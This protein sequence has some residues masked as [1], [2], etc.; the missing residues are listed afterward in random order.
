MNSLLK[1]LSPLVAL[2]C[3]A[4]VLAAD[5]IVRSPD[6]R[7]VVVFQLDKAGVPSYRVA[8]GGIVVLDKSQLGIRR[9]DID[10]SSGLR[11]AGAAV[12][13]KVAD[14]YELPASKRRLNK[15]RAQR[16]RIPLKGA[17]SRRLD[18]VFQVSNDGVAFRYEF[19]DGA[20]QRHRIVDETSSFHFPKDTLAWLQPMA[21]AKSGWSQTNPSY[22]EHYQQGI[23]AGTPSTLGAGWVFPALFRN[24]STWVA[25]T[26]VGLRRGSCGARLRHEAPE[27]EY[28]IG[29]AD[30]RETHQGMDVNPVVTLPWKG[31]WRVIAIGS[32][33]SLVESS[34]GT[35]LADPAKVAVKSDGIKGSVPRPVAPPAPGKA[36]WSWALL[37][38]PGTTFDVQRQFIDYAAGM[39]WGYCLVDALWDTQIGGEKSAE[40]AKY[41]AS[42]G[43]KLLL[44]YN[45]NGDWNEAPQTPKDKLHTKESRK[46]EFERLSAMGISGLKVDFFGGDGRPVIDSY[47][48]ILE[49]SAP[50]GF[51]LNFHGATLPRGW[52]R[53]YPHLLTMEAIRGFE[54]ITFEQADADVAANHCA[55]LPFTRNLFDPMDFT[56]VCLDRIGTVQ[57]RTTPG[58]ELAT[59]VLF[60]S[61]I[62]HYVET[63]EGMAKQPDHVR[64]FLK[65]VP[66]VW[67]DSRFIDGFPGK[68][69]VIARRAGEQWFIAGINGEAQEKTLTLDLSQLIARGE[70]KLIEDG[71][72]GTLS[73]SVLA[74][75]KSGTLNVT[76][77]PNGGF[78]AVVD[79]P[80]P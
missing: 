17:D 8:S 25:L 66:S 29:Y 32:L 71:P 2:L 59:S 27:G 68:H 21:V 52:Q 77:Q 42:K 30:T 49:E 45:S 56:P 10:F 72:A 23:P 3:L 40:L 6:G 78:S 33:A 75:G 69:V 35:D 48:D 5:E 63:P 44:W 13:D 76:L 16:L 60:L 36:S 37:K 73:Q 11:E 55:M 64:A 80:A 12:R 47:L 65:Q 1:L 9:E 26:E 15:Y 67:D 7:L 51:A 53:T 41:A 57:R 14:S 70:M 50:F 58:F 62:Q 43:V 4:T 61:G 46:K 24:E 18:I 20:G 38:D 74:A 28:R 22:E 79:I 34:L 19:P 31:P 54:F 39:G